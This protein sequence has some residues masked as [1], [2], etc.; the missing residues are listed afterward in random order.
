MAEHTTTGQKVCV[1]CWK[2]DAGFVLVFLILLFKHTSNFESTRSS[3]RRP[4]GVFKS[5]GY[6]DH[7]Q[8]KDGAH[9]Y[10]WKDQTGNPDLAVLN[11][12]DWI[13]WMLGIALWEAQVSEA[14]SCDPIIWAAWHAQWYFHGWELR[15]KGIGQKLLEKSLETAHLVSNFFVLNLL[16]QLNTD[17]QQSATIN[18]CSLSPF[19]TLKLVYLRSWNMSKVESFL[20]TLFTSLNCRKMKRDSEIWL[21]SPPK[22]MTLIKV[23]IPKGTCK[24]RPED[25]FS[26]F[27]Q[28]LSIVTS[29][30]SLSQFNDGIWVDARF[31][32]GTARYPIID[33]FVGQVTHRD[34]KPENLLLD[35]NLFGPQHLQKILGRMR[36]IQLQQTWLL[37]HVKIADFG[38]SNTMSAAQWSKTTKWNWRMIPRTFTTFGSLQDDLGVFLRYV[39][40]IW[41]FPFFNL[42]DELDELLRRDG[43]FLKTSCGSPNYASPEVVTGKANSS[44]VGIQSSQVELNISW[45]RRVAT[46]LTMT[47][48]VDFF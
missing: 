18:A 48:Q 5:G 3:S 43:E 26:R 37:R 9:E 24:M 44:M 32:W 47:Y 16:P 33:S 15:N 42:L 20:I 30:W 8:E 17:D 31:F 2:P 36:E 4:C 12:V 46:F 22:K 45:R 39:N 1:L 35:S 10:A 11:P 6:Q 27:F 13:C 40:Y 21:F 28:E 23:I 41:T 38:L 29:A 34:L 19:F 25:S 7:Q 14:S